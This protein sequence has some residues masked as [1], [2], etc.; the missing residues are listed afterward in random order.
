MSNQ[1]LETLVW[2]C[3]YAGMFGVG[4]GIWFSEHHLGVGVTL[5]AVGGGLIAAG[6]VLIWLRS[7]RP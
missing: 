5:I 4:L 6:A 7:R 2:V 1:A 3:I